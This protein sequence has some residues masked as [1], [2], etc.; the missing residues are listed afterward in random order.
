VRFRVVPFIVLLA[1]VIAVIGGWEMFQHTESGRYAATR[2]IRE[3]VSEI[4]IGLDIA[5]DAGPIALESYRMSDINGVSHAQYTVSG[6]SGAAYRVIE[7]ARTTKERVSDVA[8]L[9]GELVEDGVWELQDAP[10][11]GDKAT[12]YTVN[13]QQLVNGQHG[14]HAFTFTDPHYWATTAGHQYHITLDKHKP[15]P[16]LVQLKS[17]AIAE[18]RYGRVVTDFLDFGSPAFRA[19]I[20]A[21]RQKLRAQP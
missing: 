13:V 1:G 16:D 8:V 15:V 17:T 21:Q 18:P 5:H 11:R 3:S 7:P 2:A 4:R 20:A 10:M 14:T 6:R 9:F 19:A 12:K